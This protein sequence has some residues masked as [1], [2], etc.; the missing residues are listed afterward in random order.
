MD[1]QP[2]EFKEIAVG[3][4]RMWLPPNAEKDRSL[5]FEEKKARATV[6]EELTRKAE[7]RQGCCWMKT[8]TGCRNKPARWVRDVQFDLKEDRAGINFAQVS[9]SDL[10]GPVPGFCNQCVNE[11]SRLAEA[12]YFNHPMV[13][14]G[15]RPRRWHV[16]FTDGTRTGGL[17]AQIDPNPQS[18]IVIDE[19]IKPDG[20]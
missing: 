17:V 14:M 1:E 4:M 16:I 10:E 19:Y 8:A 6:D 9:S 12:V 11:A 18:P 13:Q 2:R 5:T 3:D 15:M 7:Q 20:D